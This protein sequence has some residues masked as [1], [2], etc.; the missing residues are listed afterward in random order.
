MINL[1]CCGRATAIIVLGVFVLGLI[2]LRQSLSDLII[3][4]RIKQVH[5][6]VLSADT[7]IA[8]GDLHG[9][10][11]QGYT[12]LKVAGLLNRHNLWSGGQATLVQ[13][14]DLLDRGPNSVQLVQLFERLKVYTA[15]LAPFA[16]VHVRA[17][18]D[19]YVVTGG[20]SCCWRSCTYVDGQSRNHEPSWRL[21]ICQSTRACKFGQTSQTSALDTRGC[22]P[23]WLGLLATLHAA[24]MTSLEASVL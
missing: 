4:P 18:F 14:G 6:V 23:S 11:E 2:F 8:I 3:E 16:H 22:Y 9:D 5:P 12:A 15:Q 20:G 24:G 13:T 1:F 21:Q 17:G 7:L 19:L 10:I